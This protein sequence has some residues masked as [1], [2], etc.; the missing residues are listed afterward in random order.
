M[1][2]RHIGCCIDDSPAHIAAIAH[3]RGLCSSG[4]TVLSLVHVSPHPLLVGTVEGETIVS[5]RDINAVERRWLSVRAGEIPGAEPVFLEGQAGPEIC[6]WAE[7]AG[8]DLLVCAR[9]HEGWG[10][11]MHG[12]VSRHL[13]DHAPCPVLVVREASSVSAAAS[14]T[15]AAEGR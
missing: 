5:P 15:T 3:A 7:A 12:S 13:A 2:Y 10:A 9:H 8:A 11:A 14:A 6:R 4:A 1:T